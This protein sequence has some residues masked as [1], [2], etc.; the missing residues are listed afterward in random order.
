[1]NIVELHFYETNFDCRYPDMVNVIQAADADSARA[2][3]MKRVRRV[4]DNSDITVDLIC[5]GM[6]HD[7]EDNHVVKS[8]DPETPQYQF[9]KSFSDGKTLANP[10]MPVAKLITD[11]EC[12]YWYLIKPVDL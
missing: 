12:V 3:L 7:A 9:A 2:A 5:D 1:M 10:S 8:Y 11:D 4:C 6:F